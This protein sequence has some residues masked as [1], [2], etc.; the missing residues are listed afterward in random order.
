[1]SSPET[2]ESACR[3]DVTEVRCPVE[4][5]VG[6]LG[7]LRETLLELLAS[8]SR[9]KLCVDAVELVDTAG[10]QLLIAFV[11]DA[12]AAGVSVEWSDVSSRMAEAVD[13]LGA[14]GKLG[15]RLDRLLV[16]EAS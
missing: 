7:E 15:L 16:P 6:K 11:C 2:A 1:M 12:K 10:V 13:V 4:L 8:P 3:P 9:V 14:A 5:R